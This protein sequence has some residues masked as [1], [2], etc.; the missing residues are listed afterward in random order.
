[1]TLNLHGIQDFLAEHELDGWLL[2][3]FHG[4]NEVAIRLLGIKGMLTR[5]MFYFIPAVGE[6]TAL[7][8]PIEADKFKHLPGDV[9][10]CLGYKMLESELT[11]I[12]A[13]KDR[14]AMEYSPLGR[15]PYVAMV[16]AGTID[17][18][19]Q[20]GVEIVSSADLVAA[21]Q[22]ALS[23]E[24]IATHRMAAHN[25]IEIKDDTFKFIADAVSSGKTITEYDVVQFVLQKFDE[26]DIT[27]DHS[28]ICAVDSHGGDPHYEPA[29]TGSA[30][31]KRGQLIVLDIWA[32]L[33]REGSIFGDITWMAYTGTREEI[34]AKYT[35]LFSVLAKARDG[36]VGF[37]RENI[38]KRP[39]HG[40]EVDDVCRLFITAAGH[41]DRFIHRTGHSITDSTHGS[42]PN[43]DNLET[44][45][46]RRL[47]KGHLFSIEPGIYYPEFGLRTEIDVLIGHE[48]AEVTTLPLQTAITPLL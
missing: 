47:A 5:R 2:A 48:G 27:T 37:I 41:G 18:V 36:A 43:I 8:N 33:K 32:K 1:M 25:L 39:V 11:R 42:G 24:Q 30:F 22:A 14:I 44:E 45:D 15:L 23:A 16:D 35:N 26:D 21:F 19:R 38:D 13:G 20:S 6:P 10:P 29:A 3:D 7:V 4:R 34:P 40:W 9:L 17:L 46:Q 12:L 28:P 31:I